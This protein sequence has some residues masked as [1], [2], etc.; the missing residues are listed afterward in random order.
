MS[1]IQSRVYDYKPFE[2]FATRQVAMS[3][4]HCLMQACNVAME[5][6]LTR[7]DENYTC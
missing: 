6:R 7:M 2:M 5:E 1:L 4:L 3:Q